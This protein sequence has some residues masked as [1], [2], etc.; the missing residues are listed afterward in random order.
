MM[1]QLFAT[2]AAAAA[3]LMFGAA[4]TTSLARDQPAR[5]DPYGRASGPRRAYGRRGERRR[6]CVERVRFERGLGFGQLERRRGRGL[7]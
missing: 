4:L 6:G 2:S 1:K 5:E 7:C 3:A